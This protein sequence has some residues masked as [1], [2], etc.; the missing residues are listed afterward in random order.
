[1]Q[2]LKKL[3]LSQT[4]FDRVPAQ[5][6]IVNNGDRHKR[7]LATKGKNYAFVYSYTGKP[8]K[9]NMKKFSW[10]KTMVS[11]FNPRDGYMHKYNLYE[12]KGII[13]FS[14][15]VSH[16]PGNDWVLIFNKFK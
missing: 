2:H 14:F 4:Y 8:V 5:D 7:V 9:V 3:M 11:L 13:E 1:M 16:S 15:P 6:I 12:N 10:R